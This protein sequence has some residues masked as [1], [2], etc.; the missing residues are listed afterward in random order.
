MVEMEEILVVIF[1]LFFEFV[2]QLVGSGIV[3]GVTPTTNTKTEDGCV[4][5]F[6]HAA[7]GG[8]CGYIST[9]IAPKFVLPLPWLRMLNLVV[10]P[11]IA[12][13]ISVLLAKWVK[14]KGSSSTLFW[15]GFLFAMMFGAARFAFG[16]R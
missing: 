9:L 5:F 14:L 15:H 7:I 4:H 12:G 10:A 3:S 16:H 8:I 11:L 1:Q 2:L 6:V 13:A